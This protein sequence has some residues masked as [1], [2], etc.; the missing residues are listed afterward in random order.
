M[1]DGNLLFAEHASD[2]V[3]HTLALLADAMV[4]NMGRD[5]DILR[6]T[7]RDLDAFPELLDRVWAALRADVYDAFTAWLDDQK[8]RRALPIVDVPA[9]A[10]VLL[11]SLTYPPIL[12][13]LIGHTP[14]DIEHSRY[15]AAWVRHALTTLTLGESAPSQ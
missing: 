11:A 7:L 6:V 10:A 1:R 4:T 14:A 3:A 13:A 12:D 9:A 8:M 5:R 2:D 15:R